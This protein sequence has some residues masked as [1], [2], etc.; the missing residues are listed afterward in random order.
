MWMLP[1]YL[2]V[3]QKYDDGWKK[4]HCG[5]S[6]E[7]ASHRVSDVYQQH[8][9]SWKIVLDENSHAPHLEL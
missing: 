1:L 4:T 8:T 2:A 6:L 7:A 9:L 3:N 5:Y